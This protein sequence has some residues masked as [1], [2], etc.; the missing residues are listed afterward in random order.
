MLDQLARRGHA[1]TLVDPMEIR[2]PLLERM[3][4][5]YPAGA[6]PP[7]LARLAQLCRAVD[8]FVTV[9]GECNH[10]IPPAR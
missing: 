7:E 1:A 5:E 8:G 10:G 6:A 2:L 3:C 9:S 4:K